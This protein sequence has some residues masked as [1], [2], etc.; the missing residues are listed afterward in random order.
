MQ[1]QQFFSLFFSFAKSKDWMENKDP[2]C[3]E[4]WQCFHFILK[5][6][7]LCDSKWD[8]LN[9]LWSRHSA[10]VYTYIPS[11]P[12]SPHPLLPYTTP[13][14]VLTFGGEKSWDFQIK[15]MCSLPFHPHVYVNRPSVKS[16]QMLRHV[17]LYKYDAKCSTNQNSFCGFLSWQFTTVLTFI[18]AKFNI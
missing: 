18:N 5:W 14:K 4:R 7:Q 11:P 17:L 10:Q 3:Y 2:G 1:Y 13:I 15:F 16:W 9:S 6:T 12:L 8:Y